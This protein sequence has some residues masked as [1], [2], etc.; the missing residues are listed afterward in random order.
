MTEAKRSQRVSG[1]WR[2]V[3]CAAAACV[4]PL[5]RAALADSPRL[6]CLSAE[7]T[8]L[9]SA[10]LCW[11]VGRLLLWP[12]RFTGEG[13]AAAGASAGALAGAVL[14]CV[15]S[16]S[17][18]ASVGERMARVYSSD[19]VAVAA[20]MLALVGAGIGAGVFVCLAALKARRKTGKA[21]QPAP[22]D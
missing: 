1:R 7:S 15:C 19:N 10:T 5:A 21:A 17:A 3:A 18:V 6:S 22:R 11:A 4:P 2:L 13:F 8:L 12:V 9:V 16:R 14:G 20:A